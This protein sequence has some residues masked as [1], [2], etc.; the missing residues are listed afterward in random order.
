MPARCWRPLLL[1]GPNDTLLAWYRT[2]PFVHELL[3]PPAF[4]R[5]RRIDV[6]LGV[7]GDAVHRKPLSGLAAAVA[8]AREHLERVTQHHVDTLVLAV[9]DVHV[10]LLRV[11]RKRDI[12]DRA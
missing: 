8:E 3:D 5:L 9:G 10:F 11:L 12:P 7:R 1:F 4:V 6:P 2:N